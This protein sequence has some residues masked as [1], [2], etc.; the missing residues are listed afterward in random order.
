MQNAPTAQVMSTAMQAQ[1]TKAINPSKAK[2]KSSSQPPR[3]SI[4]ARRKS[5][6]TIYQLQEKEAAL[7]RLR[8]E[9]EEEAHQDYLRRLNG[10]GCKDAIPREINP[11]A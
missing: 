7:E 5:S 8:L 2:E 3:P 1:S 9:E 10:P 4:R 6:L 11:F